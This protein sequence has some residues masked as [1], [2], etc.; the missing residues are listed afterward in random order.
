M[1]HNEGG[2][3]LVS[4]AQTQ[5]V[6]EETWMKKQNFPVFPRKSQA[7]EKTLMGGVCES[8]GA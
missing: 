7:Q 4:I 3:G 2:L 1:E 5:M 8:W 6:L